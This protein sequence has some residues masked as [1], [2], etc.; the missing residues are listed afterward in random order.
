[1]INDK[2]LIKSIRKIDSVNRDIKL[3]KSEKRKNDLYKCARGRYSD[4]EKAWKKIRQK[5]LCK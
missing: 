3:T 1:M 5:A 2:E 4:M